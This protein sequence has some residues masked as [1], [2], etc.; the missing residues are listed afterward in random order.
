MCPVRTDNLARE[1]YAGI[2]GETPAVIRVYVV[3]DH[4]IVRHGITSVLTA[5]PD[6]EV[7][8][9]AGSSEAMFDDIE[10]LRPDVVLLDLALPGMSGIETI[11]RL[12]RSVPSIG[13]VVFSAHDDE[14]AIVA[15]VQAGA[16]GYVI[17]GAPGS[18]I[19]RAVREVYAGNSYFHG[20]AATAV[21]R[22]VRRPRAADGLTPREREVI[23]LV[24]DGL[25]NK[26]I[27]SRLGITERTAKFH[28][29]QIMSKLGADNRAQAVA[30]ATRRRLL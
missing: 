18:E 14:E 19:V 3:D 1:D 5:E 2:P 30:L 29:R 8:A 28:V 7:A 10:R 17:K 9:T 25:S 15:S 16:R 26:L 23:R 24:G 6:V 13:V 21:A 22:A 4:P 11:A 20:V 12:A 27:A